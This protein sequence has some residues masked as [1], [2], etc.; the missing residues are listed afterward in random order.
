[1]APIIERLAEPMTP[2]TQGERDYALIQQKPEPERVPKYYFRHK[3]TGAEYSWI[4]GAFSPPGFQYPGYAVVIGMD[5][6]EH[7]DYKTHF[8][9]GLEEFETEH[10]TD[11][12][13]LI[14]GCMALKAKYGAYPLLEQGFYTELTEATSERVYNTISRLYGEKSEFW[15]IPGPYSEHPKWFQQYV[16]TLA[17]YK[18]ILDIGQCPKLKNYMLMV[19][20]GKLLLRMKPE[21]NPAIAAIAYAVS[22]LVLKRPWQFQYYDSVWEMEDEY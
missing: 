6:H 1:M 17:H 5:R 4:E 11:I 14:K 16:M 20:D 19:K 12:E 3:E 18:K 8:I 13:G 21:D 7:P 15:P 10:Q 2:I 9:R 22:E